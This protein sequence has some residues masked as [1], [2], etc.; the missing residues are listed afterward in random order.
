MSVPDAVSAVSLENLHALHDSPL[1][2]NLA[3]DLRDELIELGSPRAWKRGSY[4]FD[5]GNP[6]RHFF[7]F[8]DGKAR[9]YYCDNAGVEYL[10]R[11]AH[12]GCY[13]GLHNALGNKK[14]HSHRCQAL[15]TVAA[16][17]WPVVG[18]ME[19]LGRHPAIGL[20]VSGIL[21]E[22]FEH[23]CRKNCL[24]RKPAARSRVAGYLLSRLFCVDCARKCY[25]RRHHCKYHDCKHLID[26]WPLTQAAE[27]INLTRESFSRTLLTLQKDGIVDC[28]H[29]KIAILDLNALKT[30]SGIG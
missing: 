24:C 7:Y 23:S 4:L 16:Y 30:I 8:F 29:G 18:F 3:P 1:L 14:H 27:D 26:L 9:E 21:A 19:Y 10:R 6:I 20:A 15:T 28:D 22:Y 13:I 11:L 5:E 25:R 12:P 17:A 2:C